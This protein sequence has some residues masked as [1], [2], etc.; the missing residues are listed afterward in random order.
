M[1]R[2]GGQRISRTEMESNLSTGAEGLQT[3]KTCTV[4]GEKISSVKFSRGFIFV[5]LASAEVQPFVRRSYYS[6]LKNF[7]FLIFVVIGYLPMK[8]Y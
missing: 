6:M 1:C 7:V 4:D 3:H 5:T 2:A 8:I